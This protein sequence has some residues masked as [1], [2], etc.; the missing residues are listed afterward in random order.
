MPYVPF[1]DA[2]PIFAARGPQLVPEREILRIAASLGG[3]DGEQAAT[4]ARREVLI[5][6]ENRT[7]GRLPPAAWN[8]ED[9]EHFAGGRDCSAVRIVD[10]FRDIWAIRADDPDKTVPQRV[11][12]VEPIVGHQQKHRPL[13]SLR[14][15][16]S[17]PEQHLAIEPAV[18]GLAL[19]LASACEL[20]RGAEELTA[21]PWIIE[22]E[23]N[24]EDLI[25]ML[26]DPER[27]TPAFVL[28]VPE[29][30]MDPV[31]P[32][33]DAGSLARA[34]LG[35]ARVIVVP[36]HFTWALTDRF[37]RRL[38]VFGGAARVYLPGLTEDANPY[39]G[40]EL[41]LADRLSTPENAGRV[42]ARLRH[43]AATESLRRLRLGRE[44]LSY[45]SVICISPGAEPRP[46]TNAP[47]TRRRD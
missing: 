38:S 17:S 29:Y 23:S 37:G 5:W 42:G 26:I 6:A 44:V 1:T 27:Q 13:F 31:I 47:C 2:L 14:L 45:A 16:V 30:A 32:L 24:A 7:G 28:T 19:Q 12:T 9:F 4:Q 40:H 35:L 3:S 11:W 8:H 10:D 22:S 20:Y 36:A 21:E 46:E 33:L 15:L 39:S 43:L 41:F 34:T 18:P 25:D